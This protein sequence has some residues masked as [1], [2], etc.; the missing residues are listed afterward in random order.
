MLSSSQS[1]PEL[2]A[3]RT[4]GGVRVCHW[5][6]EPF[7]DPDLGGSLPPAGQTDR[8]NE[9][10]LQ[11]QQH[12][13][14][15]DLHP[16]LCYRSLTFHLFS[17]VWFKRHLPHWLV[18]FVCLYLYIRISLFLGS[19]SG[20]FRDGR[21]CGG[22]VQRSRDVEQGPSPQRATFWTGVPLLC[23]LWGQWGASQRQPPSHEVMG[24]KILI[25]MMC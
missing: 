14:K 22:S 9:P 6:P 20:D 1:R 8:G 19:Y 12:D 21:H 4:S 3:R 16:V 11:Q 15:Y 5:E 25:C 17:R 18:Q 7:L 2:S 23:W 10:L 13:S 24:E